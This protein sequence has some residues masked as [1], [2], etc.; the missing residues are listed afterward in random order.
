MSERKKWNLSHPP[1]P[2]M[3]KQSS[4]LKMFFHGSFYDDS[5]YSGTLSSLLRIWGLPSMEVTSGTLLQIE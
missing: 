1:T 3:F 2:T 4:L 5:E